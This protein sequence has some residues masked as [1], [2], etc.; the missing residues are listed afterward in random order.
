MTRES[1]A[2]PSKDLPDEHEAPEPDRYSGDLPL[3]EPQAGLLGVFVTDVTQLYLNDVGF[4]AL[5]TPAELLK[6]A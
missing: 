4:H 2:Q 5:I 1:Q 3:E 6:Y